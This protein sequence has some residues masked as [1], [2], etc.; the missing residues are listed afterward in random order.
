[1]T[2]A[3]RAV[4]G[5]FT[6]GLVCAPAFAQEGEAGE[7]EAV[8]HVFISKVTLEPADAD[9]SDAAWAEMMRRAEAGGLEQEIDVFGYEFDRWQVT[10]FGADYAGLDTLYGD[11]G[12]AVSDDA[13]FE[14]AYATYLEGVESSDTMVWRFEPELSLRTD[15]IPETYGYIELYRLGYEPA[16]E[17]AMRA[18]IADVMGL[19]EAADPA[20]AFSVW[21]GRLGDPGA[22]YVIM[23]AEDRPALAAEEARLREALMQVEGREAVREAF[24]EALESEDTIMLERRADLDFPPPADD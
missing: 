11:R 15:Q 17:E 19:Y 24:Y 6:L 18:A 12:D 3:V 10:P 22:F 23:Y 1:M 21:S 20:A 5:A 14:E 16:D 4:C 9:A 13:A 8:R 7:A 2:L